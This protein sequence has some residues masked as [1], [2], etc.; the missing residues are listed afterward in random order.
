LNQHLQ[1]GFPKCHFE[2]KK[3]TD[4]YSKKSYVFQTI[5]CNYIRLETFIK[6]T[7]LSISSLTQHV[8]SGIKSVPWV[9]DNK[10]T[11]TEAK[12]T[13]CNM[14]WFEVPFSVQFI[15]FNCGNR[16]VWKKNI[17]KTVYFNY[18]SI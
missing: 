17:G 15:Y 18:C 4:I 9:K 3:K 8:M 2:S 12:I 1:I 6:T 5:I 16:S 10:D 14:A 11:P 7:P 13:T